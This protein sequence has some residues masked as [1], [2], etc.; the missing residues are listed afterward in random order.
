[1]ISASFNHIEAKNTI[2]E[3]KS[4]SNLQSERQKEFPI[5]NQRDKRFYKEVLSFFSL[6]TL[7]ELKN[8]L[9]AK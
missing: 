8:I 1:M 4:I 9:M 3:T 5:H 2:R 6:L 7:V